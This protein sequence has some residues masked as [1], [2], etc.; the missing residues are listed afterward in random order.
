VDRRATFIQASVED[1]RT[2]GTALRKHDIKAILHFA[3]FAE[4][5]ESM[6]NPLHYYHNNFSNSLALLQTACDCGIQGFVFSST[7]A[8]YGQPERMPI[9]ENVTPAPINPYGWSKLMM[10][11]ALIDCRRR[12]G[13]G[14]CILR[15]FNATGAHPSGELGEDYRPPSRLVSRILKSATTDQATAQIFGTD[16]PTADGTCVRDYVHVEDLAT[17]HL[18][19]LE[20]LLPDSLHTFNLGSEAGFSI[21]EVIRECEL[22]IGRPVVVEERPRRPGDPAELIASSQKI[23]S[24]LGWKRNYPALHTMIEH[25]WLWQRS[26]PHGYDLQGEGCEAGV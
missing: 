8:V 4:V 18:L 17:A 5:S 22:V 15:Y 2:V 20:S 11:R 21:R 26:H 25:A 9:D 3:A 10:E 16:Y 19:A 24:E 13:L 14:V 12:F 1:R 23:I 6:S 7:G